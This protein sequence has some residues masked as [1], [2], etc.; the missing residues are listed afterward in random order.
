MALLLVISTAL[1]LEN[2][3]TKCLKG[4]GVNLIQKE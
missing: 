3:T 2:D 1:C 4:P